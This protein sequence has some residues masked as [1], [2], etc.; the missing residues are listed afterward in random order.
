MSNKYTHERIQR[1]AKCLQWLPDNTEAVMSF[2][3]RSGCIGELYREGQ[4]ILIKQDGCFAT[5][6]KHGTWILTGEDSAL[7][8]YNDKQHK[9]MYRP[10]VK[11]DELER[12]RAFAREILNLECP[13]FQAWQKKC[14][15]EKY[16][17]DVEALRAAV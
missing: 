11:D 8:F 1:R 16:G 6:I 10:I 5:S 9:L 4:Y 17:I 15:A 14:I 7:R 12:L 13:G 3:A 2:L